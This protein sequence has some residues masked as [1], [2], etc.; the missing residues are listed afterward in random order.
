MTEKPTADGQSK[1]TFSKR[2]KDGKAL[3]FALL[4][5]NPTQAEKQRFL[6]F[7]NGEGEFAERETD[8]P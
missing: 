7:L 5:K 1:L 4:P 6:D 2:V 3:E 8:V